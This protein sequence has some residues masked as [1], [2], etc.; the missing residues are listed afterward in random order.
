MRFLVF[1]AT[2]KASSTFQ[3]KHALLVAQT[4]TA[5]PL[6][7]INRIDDWQLPKV[8]TVDPKSIDEPCIGKQRDNASR[9][10]ASLG[11]ICA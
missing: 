10:F 9:Q 3:D 8:L 1:F 5:F 11:S 6:F 7:S 2:L 4:G